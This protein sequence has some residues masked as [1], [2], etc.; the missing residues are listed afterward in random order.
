MPPTSETPAIAGANRP[1]PA[2]AA[3]HRWWILATV[4]LAQL[5]VIL[6]ATIVN[7]ALPTAQ[8]DLVFSNADRQWVVTAYSLAFGSL[9]LLG[10]RIADRIGRKTTFLIGVAGF[11][12]ASAVAG[13]ASNFTMLITAR[14]AQGAFG[15]ILAPSALALLN[16]T[17]S[18]GRDRSRAFGIYGAIAGAGGAIGL[19]LGGILTEN[20]SWR[21]TLYVNVAFAALAFAG[22][23]IFVTQSGRD[24]NTRLDIPGAALAVS[25]LFSVVYGFSNA[26]TYAWSSPLSWGFIAG[27]GALLAVFAWW[28]TKAAHPLLPLR[29]L[30]NRTHAASYM[31]L[32]ISSVGMFGVFLFLTYYL[33]QILG[34]SPITT[35]LAFLPM[36]ASLMLTSTTSTS[37]LLPRTGPRLIMPLGMALAA[38]GLYLLTFLGAHSTY[39][40]HLLPALVILGLGLGFIFATA[41]SL[42]TAGIDDQDSGVGSAAVNT[43]QQVG[44]SVGTSLL[45]TLAASAA[46]SYLLGRNAHNSA[47]IIQSQLHSYATAYRWAAG[48][49]LAGVVISAVTY[50]RRAT[51]QNA[52]SA[53]APSAAISSVTPQVAAGQVQRVEVTHS[54]DREQQHEAG[55][56]PGHQEDPAAPASSRPAAAPANATGRSVV[57]QAPSRP[58]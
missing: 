12:G 32:F 33:Q 9:L 30:A 37:V 38:T 11:A 51:T 7:I 56:D 35:G 25:G 20:L 13:A 19:L 53:T 45:N 23:L 47:V 4:G 21:W 26:E 24:K 28:M 15:A 52:T 50:P 57:A 46:A 22:G 40:A 1:P 44:G 5:M 54:R 14:G 3:A 42:A 2:A 8:R 55:H 6:D 49:F 41:I 43:M 18:A 31:S 29:I 58:Q 16:T 27:G 10:G 36:V 39:A 48:F 34:Y 17:F